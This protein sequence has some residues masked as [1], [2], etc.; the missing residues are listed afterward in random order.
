MALSDMINREILQQVSP[1][2]QLNECVLSRLRVHEENH[3]NDPLVDEQIWTFL[4]TYGFAAANNDGL[5]R[6]FEALVERPGIGSPSQAWLEMLPIPPRQGV[7][8]RSERNSEIDLMVGDIGIRGNTVAGVEYRVPLTGDGIVCFV[9]AKWLSDISW[10]TTH[11]K[12][13]NQ[14]A[15]V[16]ETALTFQSTGADPDGWPTE[17]HFCLLTAKCFTTRNCA[18]GGARFYGY[19]FREYVE[20]RNALLADIESATIPIRN[21]DGWEYPSLEKR[22]QSL[23]LHWVTYEDLLEAMPE[24]EF[25]EALLEFVRQQ[26]DC[27]LQI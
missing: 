7:I 16:I 2:T 10:G 3:P 25:K 22:L 11:D 4:V 18:G 24:T 23:A 12:F 17:V 14:M 15:R 20:S 19:K 27:L 9:E 6:L 21:M 8:G 13:R 1:R 26:P 5:Q